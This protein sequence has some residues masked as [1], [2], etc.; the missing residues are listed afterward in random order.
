[1]KR[2]FPIALLLP[3]W[4]FCQTELA[5][6]TRT[7]LKLSPPHFG[8]NTLLLGVERFNRDYTRSFALD[9]GLR[10][11]NEFVDGMDPVERGL[12]I[13]VQYRRYLRSMLQSTSKKYAQ[14]IYVGPFGHAG[15]VRFRDFT[16]SLSTTTV[17]NGVRETR[18][19]YEYN[20]FDDLFLATGFTVGIQRV[21]WNRLA[22]DAFV[23]GG[24]RWS[25]K[26]F[27]ELSRL[28]VKTDILTPGY[29]GIFPRIGIKIGLF[30]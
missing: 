13:G 4:L 30:L 9:A 10:Y 22:V 26:R 21:Y 28:D 17:N 11:R 20:E 29:Q 27:R 14:G 6:N 12:E 16:G 23:G 7:V 19:E 8:V 18:T 2:L 15:A 1:M 25:Q 5:P 3:T 24:M